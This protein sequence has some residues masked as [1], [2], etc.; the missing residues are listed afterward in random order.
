MIIV[1]W[2]LLKIKFIKC[3]PTQLI[4]NHSNIWMENLKC[5]ITIESKLQL[6]FHVIL[7]F[8]VNLNNE[9]KLP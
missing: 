2:T 5:E 3:R 9:L 1:E 8:T 7:I 6:Y 4:I